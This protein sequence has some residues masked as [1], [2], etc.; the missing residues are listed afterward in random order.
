MVSFFRLGRV[1][2]FNYALKNFLGGETP[3]GSMDGT[4]D[5]TAAWVIKSVEKGGISGK[6]CFEKKA[7]CYD[8]YQRQDHGRAPSK[9]NMDK[10]RTWTPIS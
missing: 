3:G 5:V 9:L 8:S 1:D 2:S 7:E 4:E 10:E 6:Q